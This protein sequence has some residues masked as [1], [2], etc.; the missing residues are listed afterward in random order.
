MKPKEFTNFM[1]WIEE[2]CGELMIKRGKVH[3]Y[4]SM[5]LDFQDQREL[6][7]TMVYYLKGVLE[8]FPGVITWRSMSP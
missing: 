6:L 7:V 3:K 5:I 4:I 8:I 2:I 1:Q